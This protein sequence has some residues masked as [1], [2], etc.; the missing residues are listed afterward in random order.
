MHKTRASQAPSSEKLMRLKQELATTAE[1]VNSFL[2][3]EQLKCG[4]PA[5]KGCV[6]EMQRLCEPQAQ[7]L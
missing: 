6:V 3:C 1:L 5:S 2:K 7:V 4:V